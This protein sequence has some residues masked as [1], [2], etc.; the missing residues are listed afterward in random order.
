MSDERGVKISKET[1]NT[2]PVGSQRAAVFE[3]LQDLD[4]KMTTYNESCIDRFE[5]IS[6]DFKETIEKLDK[7]YDDRLTTL[8]KRKTTD[9]TKASM[10]GFL[11]GFVA[12]AGATVISYVKK[13]YV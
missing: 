11:G 12:I 8:E 7:K 1:F 6:K 5:S 3:G 10:W 13:L 9:T 2:L 4:Q